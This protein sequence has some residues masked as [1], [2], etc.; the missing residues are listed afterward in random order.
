M[1]AGLVEMAW[2]MG[3]IKHFDG[4]LKNGALYIGWVESKSGEPVEEKDVKRKC[5]KVILA[6]AGVRLIGEWLTNFPF[7]LY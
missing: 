1:R 7:T 5:E 4:R 2:I 3:Y 6:Q